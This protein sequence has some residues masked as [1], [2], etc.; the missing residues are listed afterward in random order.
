MNTSTASTPKPQSIKANILFSLL[1]TITSLFLI[2]C[3]GRFAPA[4]KTLETF[5]K[6]MDIREI[7]VDVFCIDPE[8]PDKA[9]ASATL[10]HNFANRD[11]NLQKEYIGHILKKTGDTWQVDRKTTYTTKES[12]ALVL[13][14]GKKIQLFPS[15][16]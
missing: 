12:D 11:S 3:A 10:I 14:A 16:Q 8:S 5:Y 15:S 13:L 2:T 9:Y 4:Q 1:Y 7:K 6:D